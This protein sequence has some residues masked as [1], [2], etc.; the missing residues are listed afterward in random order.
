[1]PRNQAAKDAKTTHAAQ[2]QGKDEALLAYVLLQVVI[3]PSLAVV[4]FGLSVPLVSGVLLMLT[5]GCFV[6]FTPL[7][8]SGLFQQKGPPIILD[9]RA[10]N[11]A[12]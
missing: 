7:V 3:L 9:Q 12:G 8:P 10:A 1:M 2:T 5:W 6:R 11:Q 4:V